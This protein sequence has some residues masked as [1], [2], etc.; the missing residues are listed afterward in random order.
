MAGRIAQLYRKP[1]RGQP[2]VAL[3]PGA[4]MLCEAG[5][6]IAGDAHASRLSPRQVLVTLASELRALGIA[7]GALGENIVIDSD[8]PAL[9]RPGTALVSGGVE[10]RLTMFCEACKRIAH[11]APDLGALLHRRGV[12]GVVVHGGELRVGDAL[13]L[14]GGRYPALPESPY[15][16]FLD[17]VPTIPP[18]RVLR[19]ADVALA[20]GVDASF[21]RALPGYIR[22][23]AGGDVPLHRIVNARGE[24]PRLA[25]EQAARLLAE[26][27]ALRGTALAVADLPRYLWRGEAV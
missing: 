17:F 9:F 6:G 22:R 14:V 3:A 25:P 7:P 8:Q 15:Q 26:G 10:I 13:A 24:L 20:I 4:A 23:S 18:G 5:V 19:Y 1:A 21:V 11:V 2:A 16:K 27:V 12:L